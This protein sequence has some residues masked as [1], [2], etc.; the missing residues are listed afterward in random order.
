MKKNVISVFM[1][2]GLLSVLLSGCQNGAGQG[3]AGQGGAAQEKNT[4]PEIMQPDSVHPYQFVKEYGII[5]SDQ[6]IYMLDPDTEQELVQAEVTV[7]SIF[8]I[9]QD[10]ELIVSA[11]LDDHSKNQKTGDEAPS[12]RYQEALWNAGEGMVLTGPGIPVD[13]Y[14][15]QELQ[16][17]RALYLAYDTFY[18]AYGFR[19]YFI[20]VRFETPT[21][22]DF[23]TYPDDYAIRVLDLE[24]PIILSMKRAPGYDTLEEL[25][26]G[27]QAGIDTHG[28]VSIITL[29]EEVEE[30]FLT[31]SYV[32]NEAGGQP[33]NIVHIPPL[34]GEK[35][36][37]PILSNGEKDYS[38]KMQVPANPYTDR[39]GVH[40]LKEG[41]RDGLRQRFLF[42][43]PKEERK[44]SYT[45][46]VPGLTFVVQEES[47]PITLPIP[48]DFEELTEEIPFQEGKVRLLKITRMKEPQTKEIRDQQGNVTKVIERPAVYLDVKAVSDTRDAALRGLIC[49]RKRSLSGRWEHQR[50]DFDGNGNLSG[51]RIFYDEGDTGVTLKFDSPRIFW[52]QPFEMDIPLND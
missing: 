35:I 27:E 36:A 1:I 45:L 20:E 41:N 26:A 21:A 6:P 40:R 15:P 30:G 22:L 33:A 11:I 19:R 29:G 44:E 46:T 24:S 10:Q 50:Y 7:H 14:R 38:I 51:F 48:E 16:N 28:D 9:Q 23:E 47:A 42:E 37:L 43:I 13:G 5:R 34:Q 3:S 39:I 31:C 12:A 18:E 32:C 2:A 52:I 25:A 17:Q 8:A 49:Q 4:Q